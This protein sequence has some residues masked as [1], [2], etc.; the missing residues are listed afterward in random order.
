MNNTSGNLNTNDEAQQRG[1]VFD[2]VRKASTGSMIVKPQ[3]PRV[4]SSL[5]GTSAR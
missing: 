4:K 5:L 2:G 1:T 3:T